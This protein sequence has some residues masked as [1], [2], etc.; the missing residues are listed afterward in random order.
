ME[1][2]KVRRSVRK[3]ADTIVSPDEIEMLCPGRAGGGARLR[4]SLPVFP[5]RV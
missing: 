5:L 1:I 3:Y 4:G 2:I